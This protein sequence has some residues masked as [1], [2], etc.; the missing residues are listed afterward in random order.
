MHT[1]MLVRV[2]LLLV[3]QC[4]TNCQQASG[5]SM[6]PEPA[7]TVVLSIV[8]PSKHTVYREKP[9]VYGC[10]KKGELVLYFLTIHIFKKKM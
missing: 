5:T 4:R 1:Y 3:Q 9:L 2:L 8:I 10:G 6:R 7:H